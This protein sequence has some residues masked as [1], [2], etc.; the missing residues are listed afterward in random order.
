MITKFDGAPSKPQSEDPLAVAAVEN[1]AGI[2]EITIGIGSNWHILTT[3]LCLLNDPQVNKYL[4]AQKLKL[5]DRM[6]KTKIFPREGMALPDGQT[7]RAPDVVEN[8]EESN[9]P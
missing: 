2:G 7:Y 6:T 4:L 5:T 9:A 3:A 1:F 8:K